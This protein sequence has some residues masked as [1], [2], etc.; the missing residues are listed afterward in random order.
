MLPPPLMML[1]AVAVAVAAIARMGVG[2][3]SLQGLGWGC[4]APA[5]HVFPRR[6]AAIFRSAVAAAVWDE[7]PPV[8]TTLGHVRR[9]RWNGTVP[10]IRLAPVGWP[11]FSVAVVGW[12]LP[13]LMRRSDG[14]LLRKK[15]ATDAWRSLL[16][17]VVIRRGRASSVGGVRRWIASRILTVIF[18]VLMRMLK[19]L[20][21]WRFALR[22]I[23]P[24]LGDGGRNIGLRR[25]RKLLLPSLGLLLFLLF[26]PFTLLLL[27][28]I[29]RIATMT[30]LF[31]YPYSTRCMS[32]TLRR[33]ELFRFVLDGRRR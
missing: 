24:I 5:A 1:T 12:G 31:F 20:W 9:V 4:T 13:W 27:I 17:M 11:P 18:L 28:L 10:A 2:I 3:T 8:G 33:L 29:N 15:V 23:R 7:A 30:L 25:R 16:L 14:L 6:P 21:L 19:M 22:R 32:I 26:S